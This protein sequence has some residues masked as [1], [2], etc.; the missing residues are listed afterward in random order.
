[1]GFAKGKFNKDE[2]TSQLHGD[3]NKI[4]LLRDYQRLGLGK[5]LFTVVVQR[6]LSRGVN[7]MSLFGV[8]QN[9][10]SSFHEVMGG[11]RIS[12]E[13]GT[14]DGGYRWRDLTKLAD[15]L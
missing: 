8:P 3:L 5:K 14:F 4:Y 6:F 7:D 11:E 13:K 1:M 10:S 12:S 9:P 15:F 2:H